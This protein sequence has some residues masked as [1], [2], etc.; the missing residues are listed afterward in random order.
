MTGN[1]Q[2]LYVFLSLGSSLIVLTLAFQGWRRRQIIGSKAFI[3][4]MLSVAAWALFYAVE[5][6]ATTPEAMLQ[7]QRYKYFGVTTLPVTWLYF[8]GRY[9]GRIKKVKPLQVLALLIVPAISMLLVWTSDYHD[10]FFFG[11]IPIVTNAGFASLAPNYGIWWAV[12]LTY[13][14][15]LILLGAYWLIS[16]SVE[17]ID[18]YQTQTQFILLAV[19]IPILGNIVSLTNVTPLRGLDLAPMLFTISG[20][21]FERFLLQ[22]RSMV[23]SPISYHAIIDNLPEAVMV[24]DAEH[25]ILSVNPP[26]LRL[27]R[28]DEEKILGA[29][30]NELIPDIVQFIG[31]QPTW[32]S[33]SNEIVMGGRYLELNISAL[34]NNH[35]NHVDAYVLTFR[36]N[37]IR[38]QTESALYG[39]ER[40]Y[41]TLFEK[42]NDAIFILELNGDLIVANTIAAALLETDLGKLLQHGMQ[43]YIPASEIPEFQERINRLVAGENVPIYETFFVRFNGVEVPTD[44]SLTLVRS[45]D[46]EPLQVQMIVRD[47]TER[48]Q[49]EQMREQQLEQYRVLRGVDERVNSSL[50]IRNVL[51]VA[52]DAA[53]R[54]SNA[55]AGFI[56]LAHD[57]AVLINQV[58]GLYSPAFVGEEIRY[59]EGVIGFALEAHES[60]LVRDVSRNPYY[61][62]FIADTKSLMVFPLISQERLVGVL[63]LETTQVGRFTQ[64]IFDFLKLLANRLAVAVENARLYEY[65]RDQ[66]AKTQSLNE[67]L[68]KA[69]LLKTDMIRIANHDIKNPL[70]I[71]QGYISVMQLDIDQMPEGYDEFLAAI[72]KALTRIEG[73]LNDFMS[74]E[75][76]NQRATGAVMRT[77]DMRGLIMTTLEEYEPQILTKLQ[78]LTIDVCDADIG[79]VRGDKTQLYE[80]IA[81]LV[82]NASKYTP[83]GGAIAV[84]LD[85]DDYWTIFKVIDT[86]YGIPEDRQHRMFEPFYRAKVSETANID[87]SGLGLH[88]VKNI[89]ERHG[90]EMIF[91]SVY[92]K[93]STFGFKLP[94][95]EYQAADSTQ[96]ME[97]IES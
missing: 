49:A 10:L 76:I 24:I 30:I 69:E 89:I 39:N 48:K 79:L 60:V 51:Q 4:M 12:N 28:Q 18:L 95:V 46:G 87:G 23:P 52:L 64:S 42:S 82:G 65:V 35:N 37:T 32:I 6:A 94:R 86:G 93:G 33:T 19:A 67:D 36:D 26:L 74:V 68:R 14:Y 72:W 71:A 29:P 25:N 53:M 96:E 2:L 78:T 44:V 9:S 27:L 92:Q 80:A 13:S 17:S 8:A 41:R 11:E 62:E 73:I 70:S 75:A 55:E 38:K 50:D 77:V 15:A 66:L 57:E 1:P 91:H 31:Q 88:L 81:N 3:V 45:T 84:E 56:A 59:G 97:Q 58:Q 22:T 85:V 21:I 40:R 61:K 43:H 7:A 20:V 54:L 16:I 90:G 34:D 47:I 63:K 83:D 5:V